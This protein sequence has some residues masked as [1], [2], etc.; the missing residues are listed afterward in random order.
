MKE[1]KKFKLTEDI[2]DEC[3]EESMEKPEEKKSDYKRTA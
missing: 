3:L 1:E 2:I